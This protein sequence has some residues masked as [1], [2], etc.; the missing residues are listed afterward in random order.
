MKENTGAISR[1][2]CRFT[3]N[4][5]RRKKCPRRGGREKKRG[6]EDVKKANLWE[7]GGGVRK[8]RSN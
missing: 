1:T 8:R 2:R 3:L 6:E 4:G 5:N 7:G